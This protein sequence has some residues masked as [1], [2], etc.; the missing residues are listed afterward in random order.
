M[1]LAYYWS[2]LWIGLWRNVDPAGALIQEQKLNE[3]RGEANPLIT[4]ATITGTQEDPQNR[5]EQIKQLQDAGIIVM[6]TGQKS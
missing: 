1:I 5:S 2:T 6:D 4:I 3:K